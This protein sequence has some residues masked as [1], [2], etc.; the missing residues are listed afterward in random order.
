MIVVIAAVYSVS[1]IE[2]KEEGKKKEMAATPTHS[3][4]LLSSAN[5]FDIEDGTIKLG[6]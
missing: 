2:A 1:F 4:S 3:L 5:Y 6:W